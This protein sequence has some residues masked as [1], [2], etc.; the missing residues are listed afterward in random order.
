MRI[1]YFYILCIL[2]FLS[3]CS[4]QLAVVTP[5]RA[6]GGV[7]DLRNWN[8]NK[9]GLVG[10]NGEWEFF[11]DRFIDTSGRSRE[12]DDTPDGFITVPGSWNGMVVNGKAV[13]GHGF[14]SYRLTILLPEKP[15]PREYAFVIPEYGTAAELF[16]NSK[17]IHQAGVPGRT[18]SESLPMYNPDVADF[19]A[20]GNTLVVVAHVSNFHYRKGGLWLEISFGEK[21]P[22]WKSH[23]RRIA[24]D[25]FLLGSLFI[26]G[27]YHLGLFM[28]R[29]K[30]RSTLY[31]AIFC[32]L[33][34]GRIL[35]TGHRFIISL[36]PPISFNQLVRLE[37]LTFYLSIPVIV[38][39]FRSISHSFVHRSVVM[40]LV[41][42]SSIF[43][44][45]VLVTPPDLF[46]YTV[47][48]Y[49]GITAVAGLYIAAM[50]VVN[51]AKKAEGAITLLV[52]FVIIFLFY[53][54]DILV[55]NNLIPASYIFPV[56]LFIFIFL[57]AYLLSKRFSRSFSMVE[58]LSSELKTYSEKLENKVEEKVRELGVS[59]EK[60]RHLIEN[61]TDGIFRN[62][63]KGKFLFVNPSGL[64]LLGYPLHELTKMNYRDVLVPEYRDHVEKHFSYQ[65]RNAIPETYLEFPIIQKGG[66][67]VWLGQNVRLERNSEGEYEFHGV[68][69]NIT[70]RIQ[71]EQALR[72]SEEKYRS[73]LKSINEA[74]YEVDLR[75]VMTFVN[76][77]LCS[78][79]GFTKEE[80]IGKHYSEYM[81]PESVEEIFDIFHKIYITGRPSKIFDWKF[82]RKD[83]SLRIAQ[84]TAS[85]VLDSM[86]IK[87]GFRGLLR[88]VTELKS[89]EEALRRSEEKYRDFIEKLPVIVFEVD[90]TGR[91]TY[92]NGT[93]LDLMGFT[94]D[95]MMHRSVAEF[96]KTDE[97]DD[98][99]RSIEKKFWEG[100]YFDNVKYYAIRKDGS[101]MPVQLSASRLQEGERGGGFQGILVD[102][103]D[104]ES[105]QVALRES[106]EK[107]RSI[108]ENISDI[109]YRCDWKGNFIY[110]SDSGL[111]HLGYTIDELVQLNHMDLIHPDMK[112]EMFDF[113]KSQLEGK[114]PETYNELQIIA[115]DGSSGWIGQIVK[116]VENKSGDSEFLCFAR[117]I[118][119]LKKAEMALRESEEKHRMILDNV[120]DIV[121][122]C[123]FDGKFIFVNR[124]CERVT[125]YTVDEFVGRT[126]LHFI[127]NDDR[128]K[129]YDMYMWQV[130]EN[131]DYTYH[132]Y[133]VVKKDGST[134]W[135]SQ[136]TKMD[137]DGNG[138]VIFYGIAR[139]VTDRKKA[140]EA[141][142]ELED[143]KSRFFAN[144]SHE[145]RTP[146]TLIL[147]PLESYLQGDY[148]KKIDRDFFENL[149]RNGLRLLKLINNLLDFSKLEAGRMPMRVVDLDIARFME[150]YLVSLQ[151][152]CESRGISL[153]LQAPDKVRDLYADSEKIDKVFMNLLSNAIKF[154]EKGG[155]ITVKIHD[156]GVFCYVEIEDT[157]HGIPSGSIEKIFERF[158]QA[159]TSM[160]RRQT[161]TGIGLALARELV[162]MHGGTITVRSRFI[163]NFP[164]DHGT[165]FMVTLPKGKEHFKGLP[166][167]TFGKPTELDESIQDHRFAGMRE[168]DDIKAADSF[169]KTNESMA[170]N[171]NGALPRI[172]IVD[173]NG[174]MRD[175]LAALLKDE[176]TVIAAT[177]GREGLEAVRDHHPDLVIT[178]VMMPVMDG[179]EMTR[180]IKDDQEMKH[181][182]VI[183]LTAK[184]EM[185]Q[186][187]EGLEFGADDYLTKPFNS[188]E[189]LTRIKT[190]LKTKEYEGEIA[191]RN[192]EIE[193]D[194]EVA[195]QLQLRLLPEQMRDISGYRYHAVYIPMDKVGGDFY[196]FSRREQFL[197]LFIADVSGHGLPGAF[198]AM[199]TK[200]ALESITARTSTNK[201]LYLLN[202]VI[203]RSTVHSN[204]VSSFLCTID[205][206][207]NTMRYGN[208]GHPPPF[209]Y[210]RK[211]GKLLELKAK[212]L[213]LGWFKDIKLEEKELELQSGDRLILFTDGITECTN[214]TGELFGDDRFCRFI[215]DGR[216]LSP[217]DFSSA[218]IDRLKKFSQ[219]DTFDDDLT[220]V[221]FDVE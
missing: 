207:T 178:D 132:E 193:E 61:A 186:K 204:Y 3:S 103:T 183:M 99:K 89:A 79:V 30:D 175:F 33:I 176:Y 107:Y 154:T 164:E 116:L 168:M 160:T 189:L 155:A 8:F 36:I 153:S 82:R 161:G 95:E 152:T 6:R 80:C 216:N 66:Y 163:E 19:N 119:E 117:N 11:W 134:G 68:S 64:L 127:H 196:D 210:R 174:D 217:E 97:D 75:G 51:S 93:A 88:D 187:I 72:D 151:S 26:I 181:T 188:K 46:T 20:E 126:Y 121:F 130:N 199:M 190:L 208:A 129:E 149:Y 54:H 147:S 179:Y 31:F 143:Q 29:R 213:P 17:K 83:G 39:F 67:V 203:C 173:D 115:K 56:G 139:D 202:D 69:R 102:L 43:S 104:I 32:F 100:K 131:I 171:T 44:L 58:N 191:R 34:V 169:F 125:G 219:S 148:R 77:S 185:S 108:I 162:E 57:Q 158:G 156:D 73:I 49:Q 55:S 71:V 150:N 35:A 101:T 18:L 212:G 94:L 172:L 96:L 52:G 85:I 87:T 40:G 1:R 122:I 86:G 48:I 214:H 74:Y 215:R 78:L 177:N 45:A 24:L 109:I 50:L 98:V 197:D 37:Y 38:L 25:I 28:L 138:Q 118:T 60:Y 211:T 192:R 166:H 140:E 136:T 128:K 111:R 12:A 106:E 14:A 110:M 59:E 90:E 92:I 114:I 63:M 91:I 23:N 10:L 201:V 62:D 167:V 123:G 76:D 13:G 27:F 133:R 84:G 209:L 112:E 16:V 159:D 41:A 220:M 218:L 7:I 81:E 22:V 141:R 170:V 194:L 198:L 15:G 206:H 200:M 21:G 124:A 165:V 65:L 195:R 157:G 221:I 145:I 184:A 144:V 113:Y 4:Q 53:I 205:T 182:P 5:P 9:N 146:L 142:R 47:T 2:F 105:A 137:R 120:E 70:E 42:I 180:L 135:M